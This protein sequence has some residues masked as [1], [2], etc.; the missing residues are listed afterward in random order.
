[1]SYREE[2]KHHLWIAKRAELA[3]KAGHRCQECG[4]QP[5]ILEVHHVFY[6][7]G[8]KLWEYPEHLTLVL[9]PYCHETRQAIEQKLLSNIG[10][11]IRNMSMDEVKRQPIWTMFDS[12]D[13]QR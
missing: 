9:C 11:I 4:I 6:Q 10:E 5:D 7:L 8:L 3:A 1:M 12:K 2:L 13:V